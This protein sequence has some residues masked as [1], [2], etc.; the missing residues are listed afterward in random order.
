MT[1]VCVTGPFVTGPFTIGNSAVGPSVPGRE[2]TDSTGIA[3]GGMS[4]EVCSPAPPAVAP[5]GA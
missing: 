5:S 1:G 2:T 3:G 4:L